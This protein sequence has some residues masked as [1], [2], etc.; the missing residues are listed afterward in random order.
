MIL[1]AAIAPF[2]FSIAQVTAV[3]DTATR[4]MADAGRVRNK[5][6]VVVSPFPSA[7]KRRRFARRNE[8]WSRN[9]DDCDVVECNR[10]ELVPPS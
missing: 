6:D 7:E 8:L 9:L 10:V 2:S 4:L 5:Y 1:G 3:S